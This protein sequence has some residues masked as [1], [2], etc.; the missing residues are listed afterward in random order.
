MDV[1]S[2]SFVMFGNVVCK[3]IIISWTFAS[4]T[5]LFFCRPAV[6]EAIHDFELAPSMSNL[7]QV[8]NTLEEDEEA[9][10]FARNLVK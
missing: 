10:V 8:A 2:V 9:R 4:D 3:E 6:Q 5:F 7:L 1:V